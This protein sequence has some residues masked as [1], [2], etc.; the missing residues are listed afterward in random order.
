MKLGSATKV[1]G[2]GSSHR[3]LVLSLPLSFVVVG[4]GAVQLIEHLSDTSLQ[5]SCQKLDILL[6]TQVQNPVDALC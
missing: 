6:H 5:P 4:V 1:G 2:G 3:V